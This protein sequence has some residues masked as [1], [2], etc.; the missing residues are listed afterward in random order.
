MVDH[1]VALELKDLRAWYGE[2]QSLHGVSMEVGQGEVVS[3]M[4]RN[5][6]GKS[7]TLKCIMGLIEKKPARSCFA[8]KT[9]PHG[10][11][12]KFRAW[13]WLIAPKSVASMPA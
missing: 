11:P 5:G 2:S 13:A 6:A 10:C 12:R 1:P 3:I 7:T 9:S 8:I 4:G